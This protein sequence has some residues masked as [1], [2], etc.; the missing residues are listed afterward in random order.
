MPR[1]NSEPTQI[2][3]VKTKI[4]L[5]NNIQTITEQDEMSGEEVTFYEYDEVVV[6]GYSVEFVEEHFDDIMA[7]PHNYKTWMIN[8][9]TQPGYRH[10]N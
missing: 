7:N 8:G 9:K 5:R 4:Y 2:Q 1:S 10:G 6:I 3:S